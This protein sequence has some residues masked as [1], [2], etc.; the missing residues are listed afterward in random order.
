MTLPLITETERK[1]LLANSR[2]RAVD[3]AVDPLPVV[4]LFTPMRMRPGFWL[5][6]IRS[7][8]T[9]PMVCAMWGLACPRWAP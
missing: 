5:L 1:Q 2:A 7:T 3:Q 8:E 9:R 4:R 6:S